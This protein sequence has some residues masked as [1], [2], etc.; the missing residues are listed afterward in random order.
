MGETLGGLD[1]SKSARGY[2]TAGPAEENTVTWGRLAARATAAVATV[3]AGAV[4]LRSVRRVE[5]TGA[6]M[7]P[8]LEPGDRLLVLAGR[9]IRAGD[10]VALPDPRE[11]ARTL[12]KR[13]GLVDEAKLTVLGDDPSASTDSR[14]FGPVPTRTV[15]GRAIYRY[16]PSGRAGPIGRGGGPPRR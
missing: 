14:S 7:R 16:G 1:D 8:T 6:S 3:V 13:V 5:V 4:A 2:P 12:V 15:L 10:L 11:P 9:R